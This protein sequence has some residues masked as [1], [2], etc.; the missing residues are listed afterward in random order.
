[1]F[2][3]EDNRQYARTNKQERI[4]AIE[5]AAEAAQTGSFTLFSLLLVIA[6]YGW[7]FALITMPQLQLIG[8][9]GLGLYL[10]SRRSA[11]ETPEEN[12]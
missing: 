3:P 9:I 5:K 7:L 12:A 8:L 2:H 10:I 4:A 1:M 11:D 6:A